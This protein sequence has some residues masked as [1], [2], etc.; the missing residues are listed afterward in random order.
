LREQVS[1]HAPP[2][3]GPSGIG[4]PKYQPLRHQVLHT[5]RTVPVGNSSMP[6]IAFVVSGVLPRARAESERIGLRQGA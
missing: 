6:A 5:R 1:F 3:V 2:F 4:F